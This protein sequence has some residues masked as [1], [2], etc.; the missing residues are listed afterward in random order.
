MDTTPGTGANAQVRTGVHT[1]SQ[2]AECVPLSA[3]HEVP[4]RSMYVGVAL[5]LGRVSEF[6]GQVIQS[7]C[8]N[9]RGQDI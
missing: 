4:E 8:E 9:C 6:P 5:L 3:P 7:E 1:R 2:R